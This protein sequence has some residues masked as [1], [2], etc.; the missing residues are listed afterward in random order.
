MEILLNKIFLEPHRMRFGD[1]YIALKDY[2]DDNNICYSKYHI[3]NDPDGT[4]NAIFSLGIFAFLKTCKNHPQQREM[5]QQYIEEMVKIIKTTDFMSGDTSCSSIISYFDSNEIMYDGDTNKEQ[6]ENICMTINIRFSYSVE[7]IIQLSLT[8]LAFANI[9]HDKLLREFL[10]NI[11][12]VD[13]NI[14][15][16]NIELQFYSVV[17]ACPYV[18]ECPNYRGYIEF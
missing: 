5:V 1:M 7:S 4:E 10:D 3:D 13:N 16:D 17:N 6:F 15:T 18:Y 9:K 2:F 14:K 8:A 12:K 11:I